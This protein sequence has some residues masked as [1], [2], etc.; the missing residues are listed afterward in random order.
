MFDCFE[1]T[2]VLSRLAENNRVGRFP[3]TRRN[4]GSNATTLSAPGNEHAAASYMCSPQRRAHLNADRREEDDDFA[5]IILAGHALPRRH[6]TAAYRESSIRP[7]LINRGTFFSRA[8]VGSWLDT[9]GRK[10]RRIYLESQHTP[11]SGNY[12]S[13]LS[14]ETRGRKGL[15]PAALER[16]GNKVGITRCLSKILFGRKAANE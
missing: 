4:K 2:R 8:D 5:C 15:A 6:L 7:T 13:L 9:S 11:T 12:G 16:G 1:N 14:N 3:G 10:N